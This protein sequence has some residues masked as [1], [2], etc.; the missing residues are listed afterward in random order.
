MNLGG[1]SI[2]SN[3]G[4]SLQPQDMTQP[5]NNS[6]ASYI[7]DKAKAGAIAAAGYTAQAATAGAQFAKDKY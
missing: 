1:S 7:F 3:D 5:Q 2:V 6:T 4:P